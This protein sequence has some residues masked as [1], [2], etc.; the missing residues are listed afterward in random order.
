MG[1]AIEIAAAEAYAPLRYL[2]VMFT[3]IFAL[4]IAFSAAALYSSF[5]LLRL[6]L[7]VREAPRLGQYT[8]EIQIGEGG[9]ATVFLARHALLKRP[10]A[11]KI[12][13]RHLA[14]DEVIARFEREVQ[15]ASRLAHPNTIE[16]YDYGRTRAGACAA[17]A[18]G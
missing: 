11:V 1:V 9:M 2:N 10:P 12:L 13:K 3:L 14:N 16:I 8:L 4:P 18:A 7:R 17:G 6:R 5:S 15:L